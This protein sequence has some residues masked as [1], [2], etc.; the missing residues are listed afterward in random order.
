MNIDRI[1]LFYDVKNLFNTKDE[2]FEVYSIIK[3]RVN[4]GTTNNTLLVFP[5]RE[6][7][8][9]NKLIIKSHTQLI[10]KTKDKLTDEKNIF[11]L[12]TLDEL[13]KSK[14]LDGIRYKEVRFLG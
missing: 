2:A 1:N 4:R 5:T 6:S 9:R 10:E 7:K 12:T 14:N 3:S 13:L 11:I 8:K